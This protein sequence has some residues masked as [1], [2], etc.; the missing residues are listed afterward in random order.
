MIII[1]SIL[2]TE[3]PALLVAGLLGFLFSVIRS[4]RH[5]RR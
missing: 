1:L 4:W 3:W 2:D 5:K